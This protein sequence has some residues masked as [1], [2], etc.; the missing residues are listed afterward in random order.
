[1]ISSSYPVAPTAVPDYA[2]AVEAWRVWRVG[3]NGGHVVLESLFAA[4]TWVPGVPLRATCA[5]GHRSRWR[6]WHIHLNDH[7]APQT[8][9]TCGIYAVR[10]EET[11]HEYLDTRR[12][13]ARGDRVIG[14]VALWGDVVEGELGWRASAAYPVELLVPV[15]ATERG[16]LGR[17]AYLD[18]ILLGLE[19]YGVPVQLVPARPVCGIFA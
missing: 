1:M 13:V 11:A 4:A 12:F 6:P 19:A 8:D 7:R 15:T 5:A 9:C 2:E 14:R 3:L 10:N 17:R 18:E 16:V